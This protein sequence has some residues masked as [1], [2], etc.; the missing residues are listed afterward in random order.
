VGIRK[1]GAQPSGRKFIRSKEIKMLTNRFFTVLVIVALAVVGLLT[2]QETIATSAVTSNDM[3]RSREADT[4]RWQATTEYY[5]DQADVQSLERSRTADTARW[6]AMAEYYQ[7]VEEAQNLQRGRA[8][9]AARWT[10]I[11]K[12]YMQIVSS[13]R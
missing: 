7:S 6:E 11:A 12:Y 13:T 5:Q 9:D 2:I 8:V 3:E 10:A 1:T 4:A